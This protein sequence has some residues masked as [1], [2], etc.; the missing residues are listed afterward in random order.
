[1]AGFPVILSDAHSGH[2]PEVEVQGGVALP[3]F[4]QVRRIDEIHAALDA[5]GGYALR[6]ATA[7]GLEP[8]RRVHSAELL[9]YL[10]G[11]WERFAAERP[12]GAPLVF[13]DTF[14]HA[15]LRAGIAPA[16]LP[17]GA[18]DRGEF[19]FDTI[20]GIG[21]RTFAA[22]CA[23]ADVALTAVA[24]LGDRVDA[25]LG[26]TRP[27]GHHVSRDLFGGGCY[28]N[29][30]AIAAQALRD[31]GAARVAIIDLD[32]H[33]GNGTQSLF[34]ERADV[35]YAS[36]HGAP[37]RAFPY[38]TGFVSER[39]EG[40]GEGTNINVTL[41]PGIEGD[42]YRRLLAGVLEGIDAFAADTLVVSLG[43]DTIAGD[44]S[45]DAALTRGDLEA[46]AREVSA[47][48][49]PTVILL[50]G[51]YHMEHLGAD[52]AAWMNGFRSQR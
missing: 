15:R 25:V 33:H 52:A 34:Y 4:D 43:L 18:G 12:P 24:Q 39:G 17:P 45:G 13:A 22:A 32:Y 44:P 40:A 35:L 48:G 29:N 21:P 23:A 9:D 31:G 2:A 3:A 50:E 46:I 20:T 14:A 47:L 1:L 37:E 28:L 42:P 36:L 8:V 51:G 5:D 49:L 41:P 30:A 11:A 7:H 26:L 19:C 38:F 10:A 27:P 16:S 6:P